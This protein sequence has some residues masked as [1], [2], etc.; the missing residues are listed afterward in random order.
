MTL[1]MTLDGIIVLVTG[2]I[3]ALALLFA[4]GVLITKL[5]VWLVERY[6]TKKYEKAVAQRKK[7][8]HIAA[9]QERLMDAQCIQRRVKAPWKEV[10]KSFGS[11]IESGG[12]Y[13]GTD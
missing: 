9:I 11:H 6:Q 1:L 12:S 10:P 2:G 8:Q 4:T 13:G 3:F 7:D 5:V